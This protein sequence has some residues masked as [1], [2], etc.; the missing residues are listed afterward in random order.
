MVCVDYLW[1]TWKNANG[2]GVEK[3]VN[4]IH[5]SDRPRTK[6]P[7]SFQSPSKTNFFVMSVWPKKSPWKWSKWSSD[8]HS[9]SW[10]CH[11]LLLRPLLLLMTAADA[12]R[13]TPLALITYKKRRT[14]GKKEIN[15]MAEVR[16]PSIRPVDTYLWRHHARKP[17]SQSRFAS[18]LLLLADWYPTASGCCQM[19]VGGQKSP[20]PLR[21]FQIRESKTSCNQRLSL[22]SK[23][24]IFCKCSR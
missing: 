13:V 17:Q 11:E 7:I 23:T 5:F 1:N 21:A 14:K 16:R 24:K 18:V 12:N 6:I 22:E 2:Y 4:G 3:N 8:S 20:L 19:M 15:H 10:P 9:F